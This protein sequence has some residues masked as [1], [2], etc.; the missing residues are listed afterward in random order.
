MQVC[1]QMGQKDQQRVPHHLH[2]LP[3]IGPLSPPV[4]KQRERSDVLHAKER[5]RGA[6][7]RACHL[8]TITRDARVGAMRATEIER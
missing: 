7:H 4:P 1:Q 3:A 2:D 5:N 6:T 8:G